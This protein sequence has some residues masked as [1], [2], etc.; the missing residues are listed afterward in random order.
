MKQ[1]K[2]LLEREPGPRATRQEAG[3]REASR[4]KDDGYPPLSLLRTVGNQ[5]LQRLSETG[6]LDGLLTD[7][8]PNDESERA[9]ETVA[10][11]VSRDEFGH[12]ERP[13]PGRR[14][15]PMKREPVPSD[16]E[17][18][19]PALR[20]TG[21]GR[22]L[23]QSLRSTFEPR[24]GRDLG[25]VRIHRGREAAELSRALDAK[26]FTTGT[27]VYFGEG[28]YDPATTEGAQLLA[29]ELTHVVQQTSGHDAFG[30]VPFGTIQRT[31][32]E[33]DGS[34]SLLESHID[35][36]PG[37]YTKHGG[38]VI[39]HIYFGRDS[40]RLPERAKPLLRDLYSDL[41]ALEKARNRRFQFEFVGWA[42]E[43][44]QNY[45]L[46]FRRAMAVERGL[47]GAGSAIDIDTETS[48][49]VT[50]QSHK[51]TRMV[52]IIAKNPPG[53]DSSE[54]T[55]ITEP[56]EIPEP[57]KK[58]EEEPVKLRDTGVWGSGYQLW[59]G[60]GGQVMRFEVTNVAFPHFNVGFKIRASAGAGP[61]DTKS[62][63][64]F[65]PGE[66]ET[67]EFTSFGQE[68]LHWRF[69]VG[70]IKGDAVRLTWT[71]YSTWTPRTDAASSGT[72]TRE[73]RRF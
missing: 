12:A 27:D 39:G 1:T 35:L 66:T 73:Q 54:P 16:A 22:P 11:Q 40:D 30:P 7:R 55:P 2:P 59:T 71:L 8:Q 14:I 65:Y 57:P 29:H 6:G 17:T 24:L 60:R 67:F 38:T 23:S 9:A 5:A 19:G 70:P 21:S 18:G 28:Q 26:A 52:E 62:T 50:T 3:R 69:D 64:A 4:S 20:S 56:V 31:P 68:P 49:E 36:G 63:M 25:D 72:V 42:D 58:Q 51:T 10:R 32:D 44:E 48:A 43:G 53:R 37:G 47:Q 15:G 13:G 34:E 45:E 46:A 61:P 41:V 33:P